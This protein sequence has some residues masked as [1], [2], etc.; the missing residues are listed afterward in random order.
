M[1]PEAATQPFKYDASLEETE[2]DAAYENPS[3]GSVAA[4]LCDVVPLGLMTQKDPATG[5][6]KDVFKVDLILQIEETSSKGYRFTPRRR[7]NLSLAKR[8]TLRPIYEA[9]VGRAV[10]Q[11]EETGKTKVSIK[12]LIG[13]IGKSV[14]LNLGPSENGRYM[15]ILGV[16]PLPKGTPA[17]QVENYTRV[18]DRQ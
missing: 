3:S 5:V 12:T 9:L 2:I 18:R 8:A 4:V 10:T 17:V 7:C 13:L 15:N 1:S 11:D 16:M 6:E 14:L